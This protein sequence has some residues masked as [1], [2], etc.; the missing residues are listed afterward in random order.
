MTGHVVLTKEKDVMRG[1]KLVMDMNTHLAHLYA[2]GMPGNRVQSLF[3]PNQTQQ[4]GSQKGGKG[5]KQG[6][7][8]EMGKPA[9]VQ[10]TID[11]AGTS[12][13]ASQ[14]GK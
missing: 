2:Q 5:Q 6:K 9:R 1:T 12:E 4:N 3:V 8:K 13:Q 11:P 14:S 7:S 10:Q